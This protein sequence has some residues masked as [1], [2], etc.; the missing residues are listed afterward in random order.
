MTDDDPFTARRRDGFTTFRPTTEPV[1]GR[2]DE[3]AATP[4]DGKSRAELVEQILYRMGDMHSHYDIDARDG[5]FALVRTFE[6]DDA[7]LAEY[8][9]PQSGEQEWGW[10]PTLDE[11][12]D[13]IIKREGQT[14]SRWG[15]SETAGVTLKHRPRPV[16]L[17]VL[18]TAPERAKVAGRSN[19]DADNKNAE[20]ARAHDLQRAIHADRW[21]AVNLPIPDDADAVFRKHGVFDL[22]GSHQGK[23]A[24]ARVDIVMRVHIAHTAQDLLDQFGLAFAVG[25]RR[26]KLVIA[27]GDGV[28]CR[29]KCRE[30]VA[31]PCRE[32]ILV[33]QC[34]WLMPALC[35]S[36]AVSPSGSPVQREYCA[37][38]RLS[39][40]STAVLL[41]SIAAATSP[42]AVSW[43][44]SPEARTHS[45]AEACC[46]TMPP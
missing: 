31:P 40:I 5:G 13:L 44:A 30:T 39:V 9:L 18:T 27:A 11:L 43:R 41:S 3:L 16:A 7:M 6:I 42:T 22:E 21:A 34:D 4:A 24:I 45:M 14:Y 10:R 23:A 19:S 17:T 32:G 38:W 25:R 26:S 28:G 20:P 15:D 29:L 2:Y 36:S 46:S 12:H 35:V 33:C 1:A 8:G 37:A